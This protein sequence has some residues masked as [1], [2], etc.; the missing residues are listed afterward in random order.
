MIGASACL[1]GIRCRYDG[2]S[3]LV[4]DIEDMYKSG[5]VVAICPEVLGG[6]PTPRIPCR[7]RGGTGT[8]VWSGT[9]TVTNRSGAD[10]TQ[11]FKNGAIAALEK[12]QKANITKVILKRGSPSCGMQVFNP[13]KFNPN[14]I[15]RCG[16]AAAYFKE[17]GLEIFSEDNYKGH[18]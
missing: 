9:A 7:I 16:V 3:N 14:W 5:R 4:P 18:V 15:P 12:L 1:C 11:A 2:K 13:R 6:L 17:K 10:V 8:D